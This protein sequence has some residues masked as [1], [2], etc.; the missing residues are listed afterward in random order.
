MLKKRIFFEKKCENVCK[1]KQ[2]CVILQYNI[3]SKQLAEEVG[4]L[5]AYAQTD[6]LR[7]R[8]EASMDGGVLGL[9]SKGEALEAIKEHGDWVEVSYE[10]ATGYVSAEFVSVETVYTYAESKEEEEA[11][12][13]AEE[14]ARKAEEEATK[15]MK[16]TK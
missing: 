8:K 11:R 16:K 3:T 6:T 10:G 5:V 7:V 13:A 15:K 4:M 2:I 1:V 14:A 12:L 9:L